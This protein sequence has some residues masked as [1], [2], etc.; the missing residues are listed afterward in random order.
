M[1]AISAA[2][3]G[4]CIDSAPHIPELPFGPPLR[5]ST[6]RYHSPAWHERERELLWMRVWQLAGRANDIPEAG[7]WMEYRLF[8]QSYVVVRGKD[9]LVR[10]FANACRHRGN[11]FAQGRGH[12]ARFTCPYHGWSY[13][14]DGKLLAVAKPDFDGPVEEFV[15]CKEDLGLLEIKAECFAGFIFLNPDRN[16]GPLAE[17]L[18]ETHDLLAAYHLEEMVPVELNVR[19]SIH[20][21]WKVV[22]DAF[23]EGYHVPSVHPEL[24]PFVNLKKER[25]R[26]FGLHGATTV[27]FGG[28][29]TGQATP[30]NEVEMIRALPLP[31]FPGLA[32]VLPRFEQLVAEHSVGNGGEA[33]PQG[34]TGR[35][36]LQQA[37][38]EHLTAQGCDV[39]GLTDSQ[40]SDFQ[41]WAIFPNIYVQLR[42]GEA[43]LIMAWPHADGDP[44][45]CTWR[46]TSYLW[47]PPEEREKHAIALTDVPEGEHFPYFLALQQDFDQMEDQQKGLRNKTLEYLT[48]TKQEP[49]IAMFHKTLDDWLASHS[50]K[51]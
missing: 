37:T 25:F 44:N 12:T 7:D 23:Y 8:D 13:G 46:V 27:P 6:D 51:S 24:I 31:N 35:G 41:F 11:A 34:V 9:G 36:L 3:P 30:E 16:A 22:M 19:E 28:P 50:G 47:L 29:E 2:R 43:T 48:L 33:L 45:R 39:S 40:M 32:E 20:C 38:R 17:F 49:K 4:E 5:V 21:N 10:G 26:G 18:G 15:G 1:D 42:A 14:L